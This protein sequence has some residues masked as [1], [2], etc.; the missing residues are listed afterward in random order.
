MFTQ[1]ISMDCTKWQYENCLKDE[2][3]KMGYKEDY[4]TSWRGQVIIANNT[5]GDM[6]NLGNLFSASKLDYDRTYLGS[7][8]AYLFLALAAMTD[9]PTGN[10]RE[11]FIKG[12]T[13]IA[14]PLPTHITGFFRKATKEEIMERFG[15]NKMPMRESCSNIINNLEEVHAAIKLLKSKG[16][17]IMRRKETWEEV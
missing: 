5:N 8:N 12:T 2:L 16:Y 15:T 7:F 1:K 9:S 3:L 13:F 6:G 17:K 14:Y 11:I 4:V 10:Y